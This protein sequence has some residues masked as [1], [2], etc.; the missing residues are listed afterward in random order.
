[1]TEERTPRLERILERTARKVSGGGLHPLELLERIEGAW[2]AEVR[3]RV[4][5]NIIEVG[6]AP[7]DYRRLRSALPALQREA[8]AMLDGTERRE[9]WRRLDERTITFK[10]YADVQEGA[11]SVSARF[12][13]LRRGD[14]KAE[15]RTTGRI[16]RHQG[17][18]LVVDGH[19]S[20]LSHTPFV[21]GRGPGNDLV[22]PSLSVSRR[23]AVIE[24]RSGRFFIR[25]LESRNGLVI[26]GETV[27]EAE[28]L[29]GMAVVLGDV[30]ISLD[31]TA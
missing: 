14:T 19:R 24:S 20:A 11:P 9:G 8:G 5:P 16:T 2:R 1:M 6:L 23:H 27:S 25:D 29:P 28:L 10:A 13:D 17:V 26:R 3:D 4:A 18:A 7:G 21:L 22:I 31:P 12:G 30:E 15:G